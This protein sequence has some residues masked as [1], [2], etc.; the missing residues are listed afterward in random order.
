LSARFRNYCRIL[1]A[2]AG[3]A[4]LAA[5][6]AP[7][8][9]DQT[10][11]AEHVSAAQNDPGARVN[12][13]ADRYY[14]YRLQTQPE[15]AYFYG[16]E[17]ER[18]DGLSDNSPEA[19]ERTRQVE[20]ELW[21]ELQAIDPDALQGS[22]DW[23][24]YGFLRQALRSRRD[25]RVCHNELWAVNQMD[26]WQLN[27][28]QLAEFQPV[29]SAEL[30]EQ[31]LA[32]WRKLPA[33]I[34]QEILNLRA[35]LEAGYSSPQTAVQRVIT[36]LDGLLAVPAE[37]S[38]FA[39]PAQR[40]EDEAFQAAFIA[41]IA[42]QIM[43]AVARYREFLV[44]EY[45]P[46]AR[47]ALGVISNPDGRACYDASLRFYTTLDRSAEEVFALGRETVEGNRERV[48]LLG[49]EAWGLEDFTAIIDFMKNDPEDKF[50]SREELLEF[51]QSTVRHAGE[52]VRSWFGYVP[53]REAEV[54]PYP[55]YQEGTG[56]SA[57]YEA[58]NS[59]RPGVYR[60]DLSDPQKQ[61]RGAAEATAFHEVWPGHHLQV[62]IA[63]EIPGLH[64]ITQ[65]TWYSGMGEGWA[66]YSEGLADE[67]GL[68]TTLTGP[69]NRLAWPAR[70]MVVDPGIHLFGWTRQ[71]AI[72]FMGESGRMTD[73][74]LDEMVDRITVLPGQLT[75]YDSGGLEILALRQLA[76]ERLGEDFDIREFHDRVLENG[77]VPLTLLREHVLAWLD[78]KT[79]AGAENGFR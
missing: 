36:Q 77:T 56:V 27:Y 29:G 70:G 25:L 73:R 55:E 31:A 18:H 19:L 46:Q 42:E 6:D 26:G 30:R 71:Q 12:E 50:R 1:P 34:E 40:E 7:V 41:L 47:E 20:D 37:D 21:A 11:S 35:G 65:I 22:V 16:V 66:R 4:L 76:E 62:S 24:T 61:S 3:L 64:P 54:K 57:R 32:R 67:M 38:P 74:E 63:Q 8:P 43:P 44:T 15:I 69:I 17:L 68:Y 78:T 23:I 5:C 2:V 28:P 58:G 75:S 10:A 39:S 14:A 13:L 52:A 45:R 48:I 60:I 53:E 51:S 72:E 33:Y 9:E 59:E 79:G 49:R